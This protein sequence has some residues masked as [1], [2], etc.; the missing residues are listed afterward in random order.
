[1]LRVDPTLN[2]IPARR[3]H[4]VSLYESINQPLVNIPTHGTAPTGAYLLGTRNDHGYYTVFVY[5][6]Q[7]ETRAVIIYV[8]EP[9]SLTADQFRIEEAEAVRFVESMGFMVDSVPFRQLAVAE[10]D[11]VMGRVPIFRPPTSTMD[12]YEVADERTAGGSDPIFGGLG[13]AS[14]DVFRRAGI[15]TNPQ[16][17]S[18]G[19]MGAPMQPQVMGQGMGPPVGYGQP[20]SNPGMPPPMGQGGPMGGP[21]PGMSGYGS[22]NLGVPGQPGLMVGGGL[23]VPGAPSQ[24]AQPMP[25]MSSPSNIPGL[26]I[27]NSPHS[28]T[29]G[30]LGGNSTPPKTKTGPLSVPPT[31]ANPQE[32][33]EAMDRLGRLLAAFVLLVGCAALPC[34]GCRT[35][36]VD[37]NVPDPMQSQVDVG[38]QQLASQHYPEAVQAY[39]EVLKE[40]PHNRDALRG[41]GLAYMSLGRLEEAERFYRQAIQ[42]D[43]KWSVPKNELASLL[44]GTSRCEEAEGLLRTVT[45]DIFYPTPEFAEHNL[46][47]A[48]A[49]EGRMKDAVNQLKATVLKRPHFCLGYLTL[50]QLAVQDKQPEVT[51]SACEDFETKCAKDERIANQVSPEQSAMCY[52]RSGM[53]YAQMG[54]VESA[55]ASFKRCQSSEQVGKECRRSL[56]MLPQ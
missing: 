38:D 25:S 56:T 8:S 37:P 6:H 47:L 24:P 26:V 55:R 20:H 2:H 42:A 44:I 51:V 17:L 46:A 49:C 3:E 16:I 5:L 14:A 34:S 36:T 40:E 9:R 28:I 41:T 22:G 50:A 21:G 31:P 15:A 11:A 53:A 52:L 10:Q 30:L 54:D 18:P 4:V 48:F 33:Q 27:N 1:M 35:M 43:P 32:S 13:I 7:P 45:E 12:L 29:G 23:A 39:A 19:Q